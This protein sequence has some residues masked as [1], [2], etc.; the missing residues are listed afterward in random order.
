M[1]KNRIDALIPEAYVALTESGIAKDNQI[2][3]GYR[4]QIAAFGAS[5]ATGSLLAAIGFFSV[6]G[7]SDVDRAKL[8][9]AIRLL[10][11]P[12]ENQTLFAYALPRRQNKA[13]KRDVLNAAVALKLAMN[14][15]QLRS[16]EPP[17]Q[18]KEE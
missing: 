8:M 4:G 14:L 2:D 18:A 1:D 16:K 12:D 17:S 15:F 11:A 10:I 3:A 7:G 9:Q 5:I 6:Q 13:F